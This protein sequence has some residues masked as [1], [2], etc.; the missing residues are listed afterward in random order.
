MHRV[1]NSIRRAL[2]TFISR[3]NLFCLEEYNANCKKYFPAKKFAML[4]SKETTWYKAYTF[5]C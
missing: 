3:Q 5:I 2:F 1:L 4:Y